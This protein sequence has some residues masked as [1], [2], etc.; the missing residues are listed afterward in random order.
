VIERVLGKRDPAF[1]TERTRETALFVL[2]RPAHDGRDV[3]IAER[4]QPPHPHA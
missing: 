1:G 4:L 2:E 3:V